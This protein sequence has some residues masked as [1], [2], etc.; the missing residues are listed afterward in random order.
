MFVAKKR[1]LSNGKQIYLF[2][3]FD[4]ENYKFDFISKGI[5]KKKAEELI[6]IS[7]IQ[8]TDT[9]YTIQKDKIKDQIDDM[10]IAQNCTYYVEQIV[11]QENSKQKGKKK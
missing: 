1:I 9:Y 10:C 11:Y 7:E 6:K 8:I 4:S 3:C 2:G 5:S